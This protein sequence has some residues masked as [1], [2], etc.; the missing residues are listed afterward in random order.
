MHISKEYKA[1]NEALHETDEHYGTN[2]FRH[3]ETIAALANMMR[4]C[5][6]LDYGCGKGTLGERIDIFIKEY[7]P[8][9]EGKDDEPDVADIVVCTDVL[10]HIEPEH[11]DDVLDHIQE[12]AQRAV[13]LTVATVPAKKFLA[14]GRNA[15]ILLRDPKWWLP[16]LMDRWKLVTYQDAGNEFHVIMEV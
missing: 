1:L 13:F 7:D 12:L 15:H 2:G 11:I 10:E 14:D 8:C 4:T 3:A 6:I 16:K 5:D 9:I